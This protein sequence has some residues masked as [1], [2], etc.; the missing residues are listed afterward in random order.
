MKRS[1][2]FPNVNT[3]DDLRDINLKVAELAKKLNK[4]LVATCDAHFMN[5]EDS[6]YRAIL[7][8]SKGFKDA[9]LQPP[10]Y[11]RTTEEMLAE[12]DYLGEELAHEAVVTNPNKIAEM[13][14]VLRP[15]PEQLYSPKL[16][17]AEEELKATSYKKAQSI[18]GDNLPEIVKARLE[19]EIKPIIG[20][21]FAALYMIA[22]RLVK[23]SNADGYIVGSRGSVGSSFVATM[24]GITEVNPLPPHWH[25]PNCRHSE[26]I[27][28]GTVN[29]GYDLPDKDCPECGTKML[30]DYNE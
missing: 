22:E 24:L 1:P 3:D 16:E 13:V 11:L 27:T 8:Q 9:D 10:L 28:D 18:Y 15:I 23:K 5:P 30:K 12:F 20:H 6:I 2:D 25:C 21:G 26:F 4:P 17:G 29:C 14:E 7:M 19:Q